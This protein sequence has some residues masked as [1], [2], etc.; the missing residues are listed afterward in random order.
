MKKVYIFDSKRTA[1]GSFL[2]SLSHLEPQEYTSILIKDMIERN[3][4]IRDKIGRV[5]LGHVLLTSHGQ[6]P[7]RQ[8]SIKGGIHYSVPAYIVNQVCGSGLR[9]VISGFQEIQCDENLNDKFL[10]VG[11]QES[12]SLA[13]HFINLRSSILM[14]KL[15]NVELLDSLVLDG[16]TD[17]F[18]HYH[19]GITAEN[20]AKK[21]NISREEQ[22]EYAF[23][24]QKKAS[25][26]SK[27]GRFKN[28]ILPIS[29]V[30]GKEGEKIF[31]TDEFIKH[32]TTL[33]KLAKLRPAFDKDGTVTAGN[34]SGIN[35]SSAILLI[36]GEEMTKFLKPVAEIVS[37]ADSG[38]LPEIMGIGPVDACKKA[39]KIAGWTINDLDLIELN[40]AFASQVLAVS[41]E[42]QWDMTKMNVNGGA[43]ALGHPIGASGA[44]CLTTLIHEM[45]KRSAK[46]GIVSMCIGGGMG[47]AM[48]VKMI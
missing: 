42:M 36:G 38:V 43:I 24:S 2:G 41:K 5:I 25:E 1:I 20:L 40:E 30:N 9:A 29:I 7:A 13:P 28:E 14:K 48:C 19:M 47:I 4:N 35:D 45:K 31:D 17:R 12:M 21:Y 32:D 3:Q 34:A 26:A 18:H 23:N 33:E 22:D 11:G 8:A 27:S 46:R 10:I 37:F 6:N 16:L 44:R 15:G 39:L